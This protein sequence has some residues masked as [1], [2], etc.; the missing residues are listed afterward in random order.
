MTNTP[1]SMTSA[2]DVEKREDMVVDFSFIQV[3]GLLIYGFSRLLPSSFT[4]RIVLIENAE[5]VKESF[6]KDALKHQ[7]Y[8]I[9][10]TSI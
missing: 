6:Q 3:Q 9:F 4:A 5:P 2:D 7:C 1:E 10:S 8:H